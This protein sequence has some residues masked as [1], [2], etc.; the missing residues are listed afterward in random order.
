MLLAIVAS[1]EEGQPVGAT[2]NVRIEESASLEDMRSAWDHVLQ[3]TFQQHLRDS[4][5]WECAR[6]GIDPAEVIAFPPC[7]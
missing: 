3:G 2:M 5:S 6:R 7:N 4:I 1:I